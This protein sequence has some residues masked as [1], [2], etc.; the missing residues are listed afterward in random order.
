MNLPFRWDVARDQLGTLLDGVPEPDLWFADE[1]VVCTARIL[2]RSGDG[3]LRFVGRSLDSVYDLLTG[4]LGETSWR[5]RMA[6][7]PLVGAVGCL[8]P[9]CAADEDAPRAGGLR[10]GGARAASPPPRSGRPRLPGRD[11][12][13]VVLRAPCLDRRRGCAVGRDPP[14][15]AVRR[16][17]AS[18]GDEPEDV[19]LAAGGELDARASRER[20]Q[21]RVA[22]CRRVGYLG[23]NQAKI[24][25]SFH[26]GRWSDEWIR[27]PPRSAAARSALAEAV[28]LVELGRTAETR[29]ALARVMSRE[30]AFA[31][32]WLRSLA[33]ELRRQ[34]QVV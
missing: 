31:E 20:H 5:G 27:L 15:A 9:E 30:H 24:T 7:L 29:Q 8:E 34:K 18:H 32:P 4:A 14:Q 11:V 25:P 17:Y 21:E 3:D 13:G 23:D 12:R 22:R 1:L 2:A 33:L 6:Q 10:P 16:C 28:A 19:A 26:A